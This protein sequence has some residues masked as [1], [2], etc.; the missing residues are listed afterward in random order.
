MKVLTAHKSK[1]LEWDV[2]AVPGL[3]TGHVPQQPGPRDVDRPA[4]RSCRTP[5]AATRH[6]ARRRVLDA[7]GLKAFND[8]MKDHQRTEE[9]RLGY[10]TFTRPRSLLLG[11]GHWWGPTQ[12]RPRGPSAFLDA[13]H[14]HCDGGPRRDRGLGGRARGGRGEPGAAP[15]DADQAWPLPLDPGGAGPPPAAARDGAG[16][17]GG[18][19]IPR[20]GDAPGG[21]RPRHVRRAG[22]FEDRRRPRK[23]CHRPEE[24]MTNF[25]D[26]LDGPKWEQDDFSRTRTH[27]GAVG[28]TL[29]R[30]ASWGTGR[31]SRSHRRVPGHRDTWTPDAPDGRRAPPRGASARPHACPGPRRPPCPSGARRTPPEDR[32]SPPRRPAPSPPG[33]ATWTPSPV[34]CCAPAR[35][36]ATSPLPASLSASQ[37]L[38]LAADPDVFAQELAR[39]MPRPPHRPHDAAPAS[40]PGWSPASKHLRLPMLEPDE[41]PGSEAEI[42]DERDLEALKDAFER[43]PYAH[44]TPYRV[45]APFQLSI[46]GRVVRGRIDAVYRENDGDGT[47]YEIVD[48]KTNRT[49]NADPLQLAV[50]RLA[51]AEQH[52]V[53]LESVQAAFLYVRSGEVVRPQT[54]PGPGRTGTAPS[55]RTIRRDPRGTAGPARARGRIGS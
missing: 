48:W 42:A 31:R 47:T 49:R 29:R 27:R 34:S 28:T 19:A 10:V 40:T 37:L 18:L 35:A 17:P 7:K 9:L 5:C 44:R 38:R 3:V 25:A 6:P 22:L 46:A 8:A 52:G 12:K 51:W 23:T 43:T 53:P 32:A 39:P 1:G 24:G 16:A 55:G 21:R 54:L 36:S 4:P 26:E 2:V 11:S 14:E 50:Y 20:D 30:G 41:L 33:T 45:E 15:A 13:L